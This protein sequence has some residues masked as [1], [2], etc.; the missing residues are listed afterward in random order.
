M[1]KR[2]K[3]HDRHDIIIRYLLILLSALFGG[4]L[5]YIFLPMTLYPVYL[6]LKLAYPASA[7]ISGNILLIQGKEIEIIRACVGGSAFL[8]L[9]ML[10]L[11]TPYIK[12]ARRLGLFIFSAFFFLMFNWVRI[13]LL[14]WLYL[15]DSIAFNSIHLFSW[16]F[17]STVAVFLI[18]L[19]SVKAFSAKGAPFIS[20]LKYLH[21]TA[22]KK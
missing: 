18:W 2:K 19:I 4:Y 20:D 16:Y 12:W 3:E 5:Y 14:S 11:A 15:N 6:V 7:S 17:A 13:L 22:K 8:L 10:N 9:L 1:R 21:S